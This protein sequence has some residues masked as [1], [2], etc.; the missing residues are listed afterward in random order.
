MKGTPVNQAHSHSRLKLVALVAALSFAVTSSPAAA[1]YRDAV[2][3]LSPDFY[4]ELNETE[5]GSGENGEVFDTVS[6]NALGSYNIIDELIVEIGADGPDTLIEGGAWT[7]NDVWTE[8]GADIPIAGLGENNVAFAANDD[9]HIDIGPAANY[10]AN[11][12]TVSAFA[13]SGGAPQGGERIFTNNLADPLTSFQIVVG[14]DGIVVSTNPTLGCSEVD[15]CG[16]KSLFLPGEGVDF[17][18]SG[19]D[20]GLSNKPDNDWWHI[21]ASTSGTTAEERTDN[22]QIWLNGVNRTEDFRPGTAGWGVDTDLAKIGG[23]R[24]TP[25]DSTTYSG[26]VDEVSI[27][28]DRVL[29]DSE[30]LGLYGAAIGIDPDFDGDGDVDGADF[31][32]WQENDGTAAGLAV[33][34]NAYPEAAALGAATIPEPASLTILATCVVAFAARRRR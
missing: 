30:A 10:G 22:I 6:G 11:A 23:R 2:L 15:G 13:K 24:E 12:L 34:Q 26:S 27:W 9:G 28:L 4:F 29:T 8:V 3:G 1:E 21:V 17:T 20:R 18:N 25:N 33:W 19:A 16:H 31:I 7:T 32:Y 14:N 5:F